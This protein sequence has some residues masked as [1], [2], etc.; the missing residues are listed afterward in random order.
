MNYE[1][2]IEQAR[3]LGA[4]HGQN[5]ASWYFDGNTSQDTYAGVLRGIE[6]G[7]P[8]VLDTFPSAPLSGEWADDPTPFGV[9]AALDV[10]EDHDA[11]DDCLSAYVDGFSEAVHDTISETAYDMAEPFT[12]TA[13]DRTITFHDHDEDYDDETET[14]LPESASIA[15]ALD[16]IQS[17]AW[18]NLD[19]RADAVILYPADST[20]NIRTGEWESTSYAISG[21]SYWIEHLQRAA[22]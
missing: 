17:G 19:W 14:G 22:G 9:L 12:I 15:S 20:Q 5:A 6:D 11:A 21:D 1:T 8:E 7:D 3:E 2:L 16:L 13:Y 18:D 4:E 10:P